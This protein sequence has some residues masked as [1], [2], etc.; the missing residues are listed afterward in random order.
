MKILIIDKFPAT[1]PEKLASLDVQVDYRPEAQRTEVLQAISDTQILILN[2]KVKVDQELVDAAPELSL[3]LRA[4]VGMDHIDMQYLTDQKIKVFNTSGGNA[5]SVGEQTIAMMLSLLH[6]VTKADKEVRKFQ[7]LRE[8]NRG[9]ELQFKT[10]GII[11]FGHTGQAVAHR[12]RGFKCPILA[13]DKY[14][15]GFNSEQVKETDLETLLQES[16]IITFHVPLTPETHYWANEAFFSKLKKSIYLLNLA[17]GPVV[18]LP[19]LL[20]A[21]DSGKVLGAGLDVLENEKLKRL[22]DEQLSWYEDLFKRDNVILTPHIGGWS[23]ESRNNIN[24]MLIDMVKQHLEAN[25]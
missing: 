21:L 13:Y 4:G 2:S 6:N 11:G 3:V 18:Y 14:K 5:D 10:V 12:L 8:E 7:W 19:A 17:R 25:G 23:V 24:Q 1:F 16:D 15:S 9:R 22:S 20:T